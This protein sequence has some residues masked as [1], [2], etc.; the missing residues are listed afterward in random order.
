MDVSGHL[1]TPVAVHP[2]DIQGDKK[3]VCAR[4]DYGIKHTQK[5]SKQFQSLTMI[6]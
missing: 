2:E 1:R 5:Y 3:S 6:T 4:D